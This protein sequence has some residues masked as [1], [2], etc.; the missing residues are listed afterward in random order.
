MIL[1][2]KFS[3]SKSFSLLFPYCGWFFENYR[4]TIIKFSFIYRHC[5][6]FYQKLDFLITVRYLKHLIPNIFYSNYRNTLQKIGKYRIPRYR[7]PLPPFGGSMSLVGATFGTFHLFDIQFKL[8]QSPFTFVAYLKTPL[9][10][11]CHVRSLIIWQ[12]WVVSH[13]CRWQSFLNDPKMFN[14]NR[15]YILPKVLLFS[16]LVYWRMFSTLSAYCSK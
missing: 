6:I 1:F 15:L 8:F 13:F 5:R 16:F 10:T 3:A 4:I 9:I 2:L 14:F 11:Y 12:S 7:T